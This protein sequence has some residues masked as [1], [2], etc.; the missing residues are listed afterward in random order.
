MQEWA[1]EKVNKTDAKRGALLAWLKN[2]FD[3]GGPLLR[4]TPNTLDNRWLQRR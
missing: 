3:L 4:A 1:L 2:E